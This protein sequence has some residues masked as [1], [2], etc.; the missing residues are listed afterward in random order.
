[1]LT[2]HHDTYQTV[3]HTAIYFVTGNIAMNIMFLYVYVMLVYQI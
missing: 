3:P 2:R 1:V